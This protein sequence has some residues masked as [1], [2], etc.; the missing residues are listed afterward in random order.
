FSQERVDGCGLCILLVA[1][2][3][4]HVPTGETLSITQLEYQHALRLGVGVLPFLLGEEEP[5][6][7]RFDEMDKD[8]G[9]RAWREELK[10]KHGVGSSGFFPQTRDVGRAVM[11]WLQGGEARRRPLPPLLQAQADHNLLFGVLALQMDFIS[12]DALIRAMRAWVNEK[13]K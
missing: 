7:R 4:G 11:R 3:R 1:F 6:P 5:W 10:Q 2:R 13:S 12:Q 8:P 9:I